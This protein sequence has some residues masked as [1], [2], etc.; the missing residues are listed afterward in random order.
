MKFVR[1]TLVA[2]VLMVM[3]SST[4]LAGNIGGMRS[5]G[6]IGGMRS[7]GNIGGTRS[8]AIPTS[9]E[10]SLTVNSETGRFSIDS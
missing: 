9:Q 2:L 4:A 10:P 8:A 5:A 6:N 7:S 1:P 3:V